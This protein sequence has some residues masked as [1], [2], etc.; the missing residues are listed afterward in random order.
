MLRGV[1]DD[2]RVGR[3]GPSRATVRRME[4]FFSVDDIRKRMKG[5]IP[6]AEFLRIAPMSCGIY[7]LKADEEDKQSPHNEDEIYFVISG[8]ARAKVGAED[9]PIK[10]GDIIFAAAHEEHHF[11]SITEELVLLVVF[12]P[13][14]TR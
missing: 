3:P 11:H 14:M 12:A 5:P 13:A 9:R 4:S 6:Y 1:L 10:T 8:A 2:R 7:V